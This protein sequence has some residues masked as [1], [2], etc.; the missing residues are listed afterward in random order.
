ML[1]CHWHSSAQ[2]FLQYYLGI[3]K[4][5]AFLW[6]VTKEHLGTCFLWWLK[7]SLVTNSINKEMWICSLFHPWEVPRNLVVVVSLYVQTL[8][9]FHFI[10]EFCHLLINHAAIPF[11]KRLLST[12]VT[13]RAVVW[14]RRQIGDMTVGRA[15][16]L[17]PELIHWFLSIPTTRIGVA[18]AF[19]SFIWSS[20]SASCGLLEIDVR[21]GWTHGQAWLNQIEQ[22]ASFLVE[23][24]SKHLLYSIYM[25]MFFSTRFHNLCVLL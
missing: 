13:K 20:R 6:M 23:V 5:L 4:H 12:K 15:D 17:F 21:F 19:P 10:E 2:L 24:Q 22:C 16:C 8:L 1:W 14:Q 18:F 7:G 11:E 25:N 9:L 3:C